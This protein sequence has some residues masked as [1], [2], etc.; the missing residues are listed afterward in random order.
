MD[1]ALVALRLKPW[2]D[3]G[4]TGGAVG[5]H[6][7][8]GGGLVQHIIKLLAVVHT[9]VRLRVPADELVHAV[10]ANMVLVAVE[11]VVV[12]LGP[13]RILVFLGILG[14]LLLPALRRL[15]GLD[16]LILTPAV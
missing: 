9:C 1:A 2:V 16:R 15:A 6:L 5:P 8:A 11:A 3:L 10:D 12:L 14:R 4:R 7:R 13:A